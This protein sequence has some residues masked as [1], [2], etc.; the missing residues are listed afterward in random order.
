[1]K[2][3]LLVV[4]RATRSHILV[5]HTEEGPVIRFT[6]MGKYIESSQSRLGL[7]PGTIDINGL[8]A[9]DPPSYDACRLWECAVEVLCYEVVSAELRTAELP[10]RAILSILYEESGRPRYSDSIVEFAFE[11]G[12]QSK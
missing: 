8:S 12:S 4:Q 9:Q 10:R 6:L 11:D 3:K 7:E 2:V 1:M 5:V